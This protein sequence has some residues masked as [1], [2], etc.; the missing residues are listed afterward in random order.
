MSLPRISLAEA[1]VVAVV[2][3]G[4]LAALRFAGDILTSLIGLFVAL[5]LLYAVVAA[6]FDR[7]SARAAAGG[8][9]IASALYGA[10]FVAAGVRQESDLLGF[11]TYG[12][13]YL[14][15]GNIH[16]ELDFFGA[17]LP[18]TK[19]L[20]PLYNAVMFEEWLQTDTGE[21]MRITRGSGGMLYD[22]WGRAF[23]VQEPAIPDS[24]SRR[25]TSP[26]PSS[27]LAV[28]HFGWA[29]LF[30]YIGSLFARVAYARGAR[31]TASGE[32]GT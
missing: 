15:G 25:V 16:G 8:F 10:L 5:L 17:E 12:G 24:W 26:E 11:Q 9:A 2:F 31:E 29:L 28:G 27:F 4:L 20:E 22:P 18:T 30:G 3:C 19:L 23:N 7:G 1:L 21:T 6:I 32:R 13:S 14:S